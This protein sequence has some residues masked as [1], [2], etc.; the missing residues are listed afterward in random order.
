MWVPWMW[1]DSRYTVHM[2]GNGDH[3]VGAMDVGWTAGVQY[4]TCAVM[5]TIMWVP[6]MWMDSRYTVHMCGNGDHHVSAMDVDGQQVYST[7]HV[8]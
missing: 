5:Q 8:R 7:Q 2:C 3:H 1:M 6:W 4:T